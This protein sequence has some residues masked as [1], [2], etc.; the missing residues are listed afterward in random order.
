MCAP[1]IASQ[2]PPSNHN[3]RP[4][5]CGI[6]SGWEGDEYCLKPPAEGE[7]VQIHFG[8]KSYTDKAETDKYQ[9]LPQQEFNNSVLAKVPL[10][11]DKF[12]NHVTVS[13][14]PGSHHWI[15]MGGNAGAAEGFYRDTGCGELARAVP[16]YRRRLDPPAAPELSDRYLEGEHRGLSTTGLIKQLLVIQDRLDSHRKA[17]GQGRGDT[18]ERATKG[19]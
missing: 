1:C 18:F 19:W 8:P 11:E 2:M 16:E 15:S 6:A 12:W 9:M 14:R 3:S 10:T 5:P 4:D 7:G 17:S 13:M